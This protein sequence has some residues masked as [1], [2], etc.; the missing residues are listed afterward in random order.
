MPVNFRQKLEKL[1]YDE[2]GRFGKK[3]FEKEYQTMIRYGALGQLAENYY[4]YLYRD[5]YRNAAYYGAVIFFNRPDEMGNPVRVICLEQ[6]GSERKRDIYIKAALYFIT[7]DCENSMNLSGTVEQVFDMAREKI[8]AFIDRQPTQRDEAKNFDYDLFNKNIECEEIPLEKHEKIFKD[9]LLDEHLARLTQKKKEET[10]PGSRGQA[11]PGFY[12]E[13]ERKDLAGG[14]TFYLKPLIIAL[15]KDGSQYRPK[16]LEGPIALSYDLDFS[17]IP[18]VLIDLFN[19]FLPS[20]KDDNESTQKEKHLAQYRPVKD[21]IIDQLFF[22]EAVKAVFSLPP[23]RLFCRY[24]SE[25]KEFSTLETIVFEKVSVRFAPSL[26]K[27]NVFHI[28]LKFHTGDGDIIDARNHY[29]T[30]L[31]SDQVCIFVESTDNRY[32]L[33]VPG[34][35]GHAPFLAFFEFLEAQD[36][37]YL[38]DFERIQDALQSIESGC[39]HIATG[40]LKKYRFNLLPTPVLKVVTNEQDGRSRR[41]KSSYNDGNSDD[42]NDVSGYLFSPGTIQSPGNG[43]AQRSLEEW[44]KEEEHLDIE[45][46]YEGEIAK[47]LKRNPDKEVFT[48]EENEKFETDCFRLLKSD[49]LLK[50][51]TGRHEQ[52]HRPYLYFS[53]RDC[54]SLEWLV[55]NGSNYLNKGFKIYSTKWKRYIGNTSGVI[56]IQIAADTDW[57]EFKPLVSDSTKGE[58]G[59]KIVEIDPEHQ[60]VTDEKGVLHLV[61]A[62]EIEKLTHLYRYKEK[63]G[64]IFRVPSRNFFLVE[65]LYDKRMEDIP[66]LKDILQHREKL[67]EFEKIPA[68]PVSPNLKGQLRHYQEDGFK[69]LHFLEEYSFSGCLADDM[70][71][72]KTVQTLALLQTLKDDKKLKTSLL[73]VPVSAISNWESEIA[74]FTPQLTIYRYQ[75][76]KREKDPA[77]WAKTDL[78]ITSYAT[79]RNDI[80]ILKDFTFDY[81]VLDEAQNIKN[82]SSQVAKAAKLLEGNHRLALS[83]TPIENNSMELWSLFDFL[84]PGFFGTHRWFKYHFAAP[85]E[86]DGDTEKMALLRKM[87]YPFILR[88]KKSEVEQDL[89]EKIEVLSKLSM[90]E[91]QSQLY[92][93]TAARFKQEVEE[94]I[95]SDGIGKSAPQIFAKMLRLR[96][97]CL[98]PRLVDEQYE[99]V[100]SAKFD[101]LLELLEDILSGDHKVLVFSQF[102]QV[103]KI[104]RNHL[105]QQKTLYSYIDGT[106]QTSAR[107]QQVRT[108][109]EDNETRV[110]LLSLQAGGVAL[111]LTAAD[112]V[113]IFDPWWNPAVEAQAIDRSHRIGQ[114]RRVMVYR[115]VL[116]HSIEEK[117]LRLQDRKKALVDDLI[118]T[119]V[120]GFKNLDKNDILDLFNFSIV[121]LNT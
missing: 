88:R 42:E 32:Y 76:L 51:Q 67:E 41:G 117:M 119:D 50:Q 118:T 37:F 106:I 53:F 99:N 121:K 31:V 92:A 93:E 114:T 103:L 83:G 102:T 55:E 63:Y 14:R 56:Q 73:V 26:D 2:S 110:F 84:M 111:N 61:T 21:E 34:S 79:M 3:H 105:D 13:V 19:L 44:E 8:D 109:Q 107:E 18:Q 75:G 101:H 29:H 104:I 58:K 80:E 71:L 74:K 89:P 16:K 66:R 95:E 68:Y 45:F 87:I 27:K 94:Q 81:L 11:V 91:E 77:A 116:E 25:D 9:H 54:T 64:N 112:Y 62:A 96:Q 59:Y 40:L 33:A 4:L 52:T 23:D 82:Y 36:D 70:G 7:R 86:R 98:F 35:A 48:Y 120:G 115:M 30:K 12:L 69:W 15:K 46:D 1:Y 22:L 28:F 6:D 47:Y 39:I 108:F 5:L 97:L 113:V 90:T 57:L 24:G 17:G 43:K 65:K 10:Y 78:I 100:A 38:Y 72:G 20:K 85:I 60:A 49:N